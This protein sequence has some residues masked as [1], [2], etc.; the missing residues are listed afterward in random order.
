MVL[1]EARRQLQDAGLIAYDPPIYQVL[2]LDRV[3]D[4][5]AGSLRP[6]LARFAK[7]DRGNQA[8]QRPVAAQAEAT[9]SA[10]VGGSSDF[11]PISEI[12]R[13]IMEVQS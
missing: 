8:S 7:G 12:I 5:F 10:Q 4:E 6:P 2:G 9:L 13:R 3:A 1:E 11:T